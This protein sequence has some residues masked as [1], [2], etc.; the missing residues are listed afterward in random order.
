[1]LFH[2]IDLPKRTI[3]KLESTK[4]QEILNRLLNKFGD[5]KCAAKALRLSRQQIR[6]YRTGK[7]AFTVA[8]LSKICKILSIEPV[9]IETYVLSLGRKLPITNPKLPFN[10]LTEDGVS[11]ISIFNSE[12]HIPKV[13]GTS[14]HIRV[15][16]YEILKGAIE[17]ARNVFGYFEIP[18]KRTKGKPTFEIFFPSVI[19]DCLVM[20]GLARGRKSISNLGI[21]PSILNSNNNLIASYLRWSIACEA[22]CC[23]KVLEIN[24]SVDVT[25]LL[26]KKFIENL[27]HRTTFKGR[28]PIYII[29]ILKS[30]PNRLLADECKMF[31]RFEINTKPRLANIYKAKDGRVSAAWAVS[32]TNFKDLTKVKVS[33]GIPIKE[34]RLKLENMLLRYKRLSSNSAAPSQKLQ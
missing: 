11:L 13:V 31:S 10:L 1:M 14:A 12:G 26:N 9:E 28:I 23:A 19:V 6:L 21:P 2:W 25:D 27:K 17:Y 24:R 32:I 7:S 33:I 3:I 22:E 8:T 20:S 18:I 15:P 30:R 4:T 34:K 5:I 16:E 29:R